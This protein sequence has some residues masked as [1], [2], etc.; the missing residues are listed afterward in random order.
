MSFNH[1]L[2]KL[3]QEVIFTR[4]IKQASYPLLKIINNSF[5]QPFFQKNVGVHLESKIDLCKHLQHVT[6]TG[7]KPTT[8]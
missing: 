6:T 7:F 8:P 4:K 3:V 5:K 2:K 1:D